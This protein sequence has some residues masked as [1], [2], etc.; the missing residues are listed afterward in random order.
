[1]FPVAKGTPGWMTLTMLLDVAGEWDDAAGDRLAAI[2]EAVF[3]TLATGRIRVDRAGGDHVLLI[4]DERYAFRFPRRGWRDLTLEIEVLK[5]LRQR[6]VPSTPSYDYIDPDRRFAG[7][8]FIAG[9]SLT[10]ARFAALTPVC[11][12]RMIDEAVQFLSELHGIRP[13]TIA[14]DDLWPRAWTAEQ[15]AD[16]GTME[17]LPDIA[18]RMPALY[19]RLRD[20]YARYRRDHAKTLVVVHGDLV[21]DHILVDE[22]SGRL[23]GIIDF[24]DVALGDPAQDFLG[25]WALGAE[26]AR[27]AV[28]LYKP[29]APDAG[30]LAR[31]R[32]HFIRYRLDRLFESVRAGDDT[33][34]PRAEAEIAAL[35][36]RPEALSAH[37]DDRRR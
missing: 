9:V 21:G 31:S 22:G 24:S 5:R 30:L 13:D 11:R 35:L 16:R 2:V 12:L 25:F 7:Y 23:T 26:A 8:P 29:A 17:R 27:R 28:D 19:D 18:R 37:H 6:S 36:D 4:V 15:F 32:R 3:P 10:P 14:T 1:M 34:W 33:D 20:F